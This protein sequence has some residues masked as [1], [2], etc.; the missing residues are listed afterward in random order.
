MRASSPSTPLSGWSDAPLWIF[1]VVQARMGYFEILEKLVKRSV[2][3]VLV[4]CLLRPDQL[5]RACPQHLSNKK[6][7][8]CRWAGAAPDAAELKARPTVAKPDSAVHDATSSQQQTPGA[9]TQSMAYPPG[10]SSNSTS[11][12]P[13]SAHANSHHDLHQRPTGQ[14]GRASMHSTGKASMHS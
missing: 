2:K 9:T 10:A 4:W 3:L 6:L 14:T 1:Q 12:Q 13:S 7:R 8:G 11:H 5:Y